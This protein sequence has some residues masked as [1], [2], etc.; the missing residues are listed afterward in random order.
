LP[1][2]DRG[3]IDVTTSTARRG[4]SSA[5]TWARKSIE[6]CPEMSAALSE[7]SRPVS[8]AQIIG[9]SARSPIFASVPA[10]SSRAASAACC[11]AARSSS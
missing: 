2:A 9:P 1:K 8:R 10:G 3:G 11:S 5:A 4:S 6:K 7:W